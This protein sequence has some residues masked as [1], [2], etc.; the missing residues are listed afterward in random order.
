MALNFLGFFNWSANF[1]IFIQITKKK[2]DLLKYRVNFIWIEELK[3]TKALV[4]II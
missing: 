4:V 1:G 3:T 2:I